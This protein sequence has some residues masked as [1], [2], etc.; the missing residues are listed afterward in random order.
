MNT[1]PERLGEY[2]ALGHEQRLDLL[3]SLQRQKAALAA[4][5]QVLLHAIVADPP[6]AMLA[7]DPEWDER[8]VLNE[9]ACTLRISPRTIEHRASIAEQLVAVLPS[10]LAALTAGTISLP[11]ALRLAEATVGL[12]EEVST[13]VE[14]AVLPRAGAQTPGQFA[15]SI[16]KAVARQDTRQHERRHEDAR[17]ERRV[18]FTPRENGMCDLWAHL[19]ADAAAAIRDLLYRTAAQ[20]KG[21]RRDQD[22]GAEGERT[23]D[24]RR[25]DTLVDLIL[26]RA[27]PADPG[28]DRPGGD[29]EHGRHGGGEHGSGEHGSD[30]G[31]SDGGDSEHG[32]G[33]RA[34]P[35]QRA[36]RR[37][38]ARRRRVRVHVTVAL[39]TL[40][41][42]DE[43]GGDLAGHGPIP[44]AL[45]RALA[46]DPTGTW[47][48]ILTD[49]YGHYLRA[50][51]RTYRPA[52]AL[53]RHI[54]LRDQTCRFAG[55]R[56]DAGHAEIDHILAWADGGET[57]PEN[58]QA[59]CPNH[60]RV[61]HQTQWRVERCTDGST[62]WTS[63]AGHS[64]LQPPPDPLP[65]DTTMTALIY[66]PAP[67]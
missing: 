19:P 58:L 4:A 30:G 44:A 15:A 17:A 22:G 52:A 66:E 23:A 41:G 57:T 51:A 13:R 18:V 7:P 36:Q 50:G 25:A 43:Q 56:A 37:Q 67:F 53:D 45:A 16:R 12:P 34:R 1:S 42:L 46:F 65:V 33:R 49:D 9:L 59:L 61:K 54:R 38:R 35:R 40:L 32:R 48:R 5:E 2:L 3:V 27:D 10:T 20:A 62:R 6:V 24:Q 31:D 8:S 64:Y 28:G 39:S 21:R 63:P 60:H 47:R 29:S 55:C 11:H 26:D 14:A